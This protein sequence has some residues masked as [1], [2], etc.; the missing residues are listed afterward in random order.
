MDF[1]YEGG[2]A[3]GKGGTVTL[4]V[5]G[6]AVGSGRVEKTTPYKFSLSEN[7]DIGTDTGTPVTS[8]YRAPFTFEGR[9]EEVVVDLKK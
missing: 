5:D 9:L 2:Q 7:Q 1:A 6:Q 3:V 8:D 4:F